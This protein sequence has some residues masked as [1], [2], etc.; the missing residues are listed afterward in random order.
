MAVKV[1]DP[2]VGGDRDGHSRGEVRGEVSGQ[3]VDAR[4]GDGKGYRG[5][6][7][8][9]GGLSLGRAGG[10]CQPQ[11]KQ[12]RERSGEEGNMWSHGGPPLIVTPGVD[13]AVWMIERGADPTSQV[14]AYFAGAGGV[15]D[16]NPKLR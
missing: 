12:H 11:E 6:R 16:A 8:T 2:V 4:G 14:V 1:Q 5:D 7:R 15:V 3:A 13:D 10:T 9:A